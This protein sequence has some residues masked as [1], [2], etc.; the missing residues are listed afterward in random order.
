[1]RRRYERVAIRRFYRL[2]R[3]S[4]TAATLRREPRDVERADA[5]GE[6]DKDARA[7]RRVAD[8][9]GRDES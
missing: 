8:A 9:P 6:D 5:A 1:M 3:N 7:M 4:Q 2:S